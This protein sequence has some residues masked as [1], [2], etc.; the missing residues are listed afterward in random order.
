MSTGLRARCSRKRRLKRN[1][2]R[3]SAWTPQRS[4]RW[5]L[6]E[7]EGRARPVGPPSPAPL[8]DSSPA[9]PCVGRPLQDGM[10]LLLYRTVL[11]RRWRHAPGAR[12]SISQ[13]LGAWLDAQRAAPEP[14][15]PALAPRVRPPSPR[16]TSAP[17]GGPFA[18]QHRF[19]EPFDA[20]AVRL[21]L[22]PLPG[23]GRRGARLRARLLAAG[24]GRGGPLRA[25]PHG[26]GAWSPS[27]SGAATSSAAVSPRAEDA[28]HGD[29]HVR[30]DAAR[31]A[32]PESEEKRREYYAHDH[33]AESERLSR[34]IDNV[35]EFSRLER[36]TRATSS[37]ARRPLGPGP[38]G[39]GRGSA[40]TP[41]A[42]ASRFEI[43]VA[44]GLPPVRFERDALLQI[45]FNLVDNALKYARG[46]RGP[47]GRAALPRRDGGRVLL[48]RARP[49]PRRARARTSRA[50]S[51]PST[52]ATTS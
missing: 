17:P 21:A 8:E 7:E 35:L 15:R 20:L 10:H 26:G 43:D 2:G 39:R 52:A 13:R 34:L 37:S 24:R 42:R 40:P 22:A 46:A 28:A 49:R 30:R 36:G 31:R 19:A 11:R 41:S 29:P 12:R 14:P 32:G 5:A 44:P 45:L 25:P 18:Y 3:D 9:S 4:E 1:V 33:G 16:R 27:P 47:H 38:R 23:V 50:S 51:S 48:A 6:L